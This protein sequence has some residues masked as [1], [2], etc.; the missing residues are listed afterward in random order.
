MFFVPGLL[1]HTIREFFWD[2]LRSVNLLQPGRPGSEP[3]T[4]TFRTNEQVWQQLLSQHSLGWVTLR[5]FSLTDWYPRSP[6]TYH[7]P[8]ARYSREHANYYVRSENGIDFYEPRGKASMMDGGIGS[9]RFKPVR[10]NNET[11]WLGTAT[12][13]GVCHSGIPIAIPEA[14]TR[15]LDFNFGVRASVTG[16]FHFVPDSLETY[17]AHVLRVPQ[18]YVLVDALH[19]ITTRPGFV[20]ITPMVFFDGHNPTRTAERGNV[21]FVTCGDSGYTEIDAA[22]DYLT[23]YVDR[24]GGKIVTNFDQ[25]RRVFANAPFSLQNVLTAK[26]LLST[27]Y[28]RLRQ[29]QLIC[30]LGSM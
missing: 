17:F 16:Q 11:Y 10:V 27:L 12:S 29:G 30:H 22:A 1:S 18:I 20:D 3:H 25:Q 4:V 13:D 9:V 26:I 2:H 19:D 23:T 21:T 5:D 28:K 14:L 8:Q 6:G 7:I 15:K 24:Y